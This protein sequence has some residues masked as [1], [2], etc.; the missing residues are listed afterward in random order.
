M[1]VTVTDPDFN[2]PELEDWKSYVVTNGYRPKI[3]QIQKSHSQSA[4]G[5]GTQEGA[6]LLD[7]CGS[8]GP[9]C[10]KKS[11]FYLKTCTPVKGTL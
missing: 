6:I 9:S 5:G 11:L 8:P 10:S 1:T 4:S 7:F 3:V 2:F